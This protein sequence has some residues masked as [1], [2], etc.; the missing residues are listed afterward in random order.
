MGEKPTGCCIFGEDLPT[1]TLHRIITG[2]IEHVFLHVT[3]DLNFLA[4]AP[5]LPAEQNNNL[6]LSAP[7]FFTDLTFPP[8][9][10]RVSL[11]GCI[12]SK[13]ERDGNADV[14]ATWI[15]PSL[16]DEAS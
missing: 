15:Y 5:P 4:A 8:S 16:S 11:P 12:A 10:S 14:L 1:A 2:L 9:C 7:L 6:F 13:T 3:A